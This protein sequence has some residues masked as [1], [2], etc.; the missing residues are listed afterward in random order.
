MGLLGVDR[1]S[2][3]QLALESRTKSYPHRFQLGQL[4]H[5]AKIRKPVWR[6]KAAPSQVDACNGELTLTK[7]KVAAQS[8]KR[9]RAGRSVRG[10]FQ[11]DQ[12]SVFRL[13]RAG[14]REGR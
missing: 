6:P 12:I 4:G 2:R 13:L 14:A 9:L 7:A 1:G 8:P 3:H 11:A 10:E 5:E